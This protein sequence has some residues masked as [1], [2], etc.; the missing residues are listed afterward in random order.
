M[1]VYVWSRY[2][3][4]RRMMSF[5]LDMNL[6]D[7]TLQSLRASVWMLLQRVRHTVAD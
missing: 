6:S 3:L 2:K 7:I 4:V 1:S 5:R